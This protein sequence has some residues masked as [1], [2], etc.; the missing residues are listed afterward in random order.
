[1]WTPTPQGSKQKEREGV[2]SVRL[3]SLGHCEYCL[4]AWE[5]VC[6]QARF[7]G[8]TQNGGFAEYILADP[9]LPAG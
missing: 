7:G 2:D 3:R 8:Y 9:A 4:T 5:T 6:A 1:M